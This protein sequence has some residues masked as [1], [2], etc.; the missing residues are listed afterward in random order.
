MQLNVRDVAGIFNI[1]EKT[2]FRWIKH[3]IFQFIM[4]MKSTG[5]AVRNLNPHKG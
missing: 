1:S 3:K 4:L 2:V 5:S